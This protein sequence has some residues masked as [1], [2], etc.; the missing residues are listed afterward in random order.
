MHRHGHG[1]CRDCAAVRGLY[2]SSGWIDDA[3]F[4]PDGNLIAFVDHSVINDD[5]GSITVVDRNGSKRTLAAGWTSAQRLAWNPSGSE[6]WFTASDLGGNRALHAVT[7]DGRQR[8]IDTVPGSLTLE[9]IAADG[10]VLLTHNRDRQELF[11]RLPGDRNDRDL[12]W[13]DWSGLPCL[14]ADGRTVVFSEAGEGGGATYGVFRRKTDGSPA[15][16]LGDGTALALSSDG[17]LVLASGSP[18]SPRAIMQLSTG[19]GESH[20]V[21]IGDLT[22]AAAE[23]LPDG[24]RLLFAA[25]ESD[26]PARVFVSDGI[27]SR[28]R[29]LTP[30]G[31]GAGR[32]L[33]ISPDGRIVIVRDP[34]RNVLMWPIEGGDPRPV[35]WLNRDEVPIRW[36]ADGRSLFVAKQAGIHISIYQGDIATGRRQP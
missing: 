24:K 4:S 17:K 18:T 30:E 13:F 14:S 21:E 19:A 34:K 1:P 31:T 33:V 8:L 23:W 27:S 36:S 16:R 6:V 20:P 26:H 9:D 28:P 7:I 35:S 3:R 10:R 32:R 2:Q 29:P 22:V 25:S 12:S 11:G 15:I 5:A